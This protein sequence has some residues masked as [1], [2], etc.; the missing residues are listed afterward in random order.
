M[1]LP[2][3]PNVRTGWMLGGER[4]KVCRNI[5]LVAKSRQGRINAGDVGVCRNLPLVPKVRQSGM[6]AGGEGMQEPENVD[7]SPIHLPA[8][9]NIIKD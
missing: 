8:T 4:A 9:P 1:N 3:D 7:P 2:L 6:D 5:P